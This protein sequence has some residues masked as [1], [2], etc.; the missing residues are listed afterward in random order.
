MIAPQ[1]GRANHIKKKNGVNNHSTQSSW[2]VKVNMPTDMNPGINM[3][4]IDKT[5]R[6]AG[7][8]MHVAKNPSKL[9]KGKPTKTKIPETGL[10]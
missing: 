7:T 4:K 8:R 3:P 2:R 1:T 10:P 5:Q 9:H 6:E